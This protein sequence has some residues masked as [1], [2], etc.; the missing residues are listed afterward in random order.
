LFDD[1]KFINVGFITVDT[2]EQAGPPQYNNELIQ[3]SNNQVTVLSSGEIISTCDGSSSLQVDE[4]SKI[5]S[6]QLKKLQFIC[7][8]APPS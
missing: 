8:Y 2:D 1:Y 6:M 4:N 5:T 3:N 7:Q